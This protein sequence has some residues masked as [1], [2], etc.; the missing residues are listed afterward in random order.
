[1]SGAG[2]CAGS[3]G[4]S[5]QSDAAAITCTI[6][7]QDGAG[8]SW[9]STCNGGTCSCVYNHTEMCTCMLGADAGSCFSCCPGTH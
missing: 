9:E 4:G 7:C 1:M 8:N 6:A 3:T 5:A 2:S